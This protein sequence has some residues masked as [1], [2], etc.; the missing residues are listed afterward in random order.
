MPASPRPCG[1]RRSAPPGGGGGVGRPGVDLRDLPFVTIDPPGSRDLD[2]A[3]FIER[4]EDGLPR[5]L[6]HRRRGRLRGAGRRGGGGGV[7]SGGVT[8]YSPDQREPLYPAVL[9]QGAA[10]LLP[11]GDRPCGA[12]LAGAGRARARSSRDATE[13]ARV[14]SR[15]QLTY[16][17]GAAAVEHGGSRSGRGRSRSRC[18]CCARWASCGGSASASAAASRSRSATSTCSSA[19]RPAPRATSWC[20]RSRTRR[21]SGTRRSPCSPGTPARSGCCR[22]AW[23]C[24]AP[25]RRRARSDV[26]ALPGRRARARLRVA[27]GASV[28]R[29][30]PRPRPGR[31]ARDALVW[32][33]RRLMRGADYVAFDGEPPDHRAHSALAMPYAHCTAPLRRLAD[34]YVLDLL[35]RAGGRSA[36]ADRGEW[37]RCAA[38]GGD[39]RRRAP[40]QP[41]GAPRGGHRRGLGA[42]GPGGRDLPR[43]GARRCAPT[44]WRPSSPTRPIRARVAVTDG[45]PPLALGEPVRV[46]LGAPRR[47]GGDRRVRARLTSAEVRGAKCQRAGP[48]P[49]R[50]SIAGSGSRCAGATA[51]PAAC[52]SRSPGTSPARRPGSC[53]G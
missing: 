12:L 5:W 3:L 49:S 27:R 37:T 11:D 30:H 21:R 1:G 43:R 18:S 9:S 8:Y 15:A 4:R 51:I 41:P 48:R 34:R 26:D 31:P 36:A 52:G 22:R 38:P 33:A 7:A 35:A 28:R 45:A 50:S 25:W 53:E 2:Q 44:A 32:Q 19:A 14:R 46:R 39:G 23:G 20:T 16:A 42:A 17:A 47:R 24:C 6:R 40:R 29:V 10:S 13:R